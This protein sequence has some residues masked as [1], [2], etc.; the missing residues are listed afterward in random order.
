MESTTTMSSV[1][2]VRAENNR[3]IS[4]SVIGTRTMAPEPKGPKLNI[5]M[6]S[7]VSVTTVLDEMR[8]HSKDGGSTRILKSSA[9]RRS[10]ATL[11]CSSRVHPATPT[12]PALTS[13]LPRWLG[14]CRWQTSESGCLLCP[15]EYSLLRTVPLRAVT[16]R[17]HT[18]PRNR[19]R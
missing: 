3:E 11:S 8:G 19:L 18:V 13:R 9:C 7:V 5:R 17:N 4:S 16:R 6:S 10:N 2:A 15:R 12:P 1:E 14:V